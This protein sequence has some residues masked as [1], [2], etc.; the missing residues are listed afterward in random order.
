MFKKL[1]RLLLIALAI[2]LLRAALSGLKSSASESRGHNGDTRR[3]VIGADLNEADIATVYSLFGVERGSVTELKLSNTEERAYLQSGVDTGSIGTRTVSC[4]YMEL[5]PEG[6]GLSI[7]TS[8]LDWS[9][10]MY[11]SALA[12]AGIAD[13]RILVAAPYPVTGT[14]ALAGIYKAYEDIT[15][16]RLKAENKSAGTQELSLLGEL[17]RQV[18]SVDSTVIVREVKQLLDQGAALS[19]WELR[20]QI[21]QISSRLHVIL[22]E[23]QLMQIIALVRSLQ[24][25]DADA[26]QQRVDGLRGAMQRV[27]ETREKAETVV[28]EAGEAVRAVGSFFRS[29]R[30]LFR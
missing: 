10:E 7:Q 16:S 22:T 20:E 13:A 9:P 6:S 15:G 18:G 26:L 1:F 30:D 25:L 23:D 2:V 29:V 4:V 28:E 8:N 11:A 5:L 14:G 3:T 21:L 12:T 27:S 24:G 17:S 19:D